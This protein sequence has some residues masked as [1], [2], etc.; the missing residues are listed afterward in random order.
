MPAMACT[1]P[2]LQPRSSATTR[3]ASARCRPAVSALHWPQ[4]SSARLPSSCGRTH[5]QGR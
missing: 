5:G 2:R 3:R 4:S 1:M